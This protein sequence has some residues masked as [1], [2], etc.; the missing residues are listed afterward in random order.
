LIFSTTKENTM[1]E[2]QSA[3]LL[4]VDDEA[5]VLF[6]LTRMLQSRGYMVSPATNGTEALALILRDSFELLLIDLHLPDMSGLDIAR[7]MRAHQPEAA[8]I[9]I[10]GST[11]IGG[12]SIADQ[13]SPFDCILKTAGPQE[14][15]HR[16]ATALQ[17][18]PIA[19]ATGGF[20]A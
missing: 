10:S 8:I 19:R 9:L 1:V 18:R 17:H 13:V 15:L 4:V 7:H 16:V 14:V 5:A 11:E 6:T 3:R 2:Q 20:V 12:V